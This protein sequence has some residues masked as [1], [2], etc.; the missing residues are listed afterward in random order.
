MDFPGLS[1]GQLEI[2]LL[3]VAQVPLLLSL[4]GVQLE[5]V[6]TEASGGGKLLIRAGF[7]LVLGSSWL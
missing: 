5:C 1:A 4:L 2:R 3:L 6:P 7:W